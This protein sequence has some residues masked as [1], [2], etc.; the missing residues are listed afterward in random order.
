MLYIPYM[1]KG[2]TNKILTYDRDIL[3]N[4]KILYIS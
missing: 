3:N 1:V 2:D 4:K